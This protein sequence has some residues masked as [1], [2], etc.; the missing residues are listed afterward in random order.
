MTSTPPSRPVPGRNRLFT[1][2]ASVL[3]VTAVL[4]VLQFPF[5]EARLAL[6]RDPDAGASVAGAGVL[7]AV[8][9]CCCRWPGRA[10]PRSR[11][12]RGLAAGRLRPRYAAAVW[13]RHRQLPVA[14]SRHLEIPA[15]RD[16]RL[17]A[18]VDDM[19]ARRR[20]ARRRQGLQRP[21]GG[22]R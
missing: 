3:A 5:P 11:V 14:G 6:W 19:P 12:G 16:R 8:C 2:T 20:Q 10:S 9:A 22:L 21:E 1:A 18:G 13:D 15:G 7:G 17:G 4:T